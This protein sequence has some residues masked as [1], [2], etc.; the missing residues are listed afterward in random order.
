MV[1]DAV[2]DPAA[3][4]GSGEVPQTRRYDQGAGTAGG[5]AERYCGGDG[6]A[7]SQGQ[8][9]RQFSGEKDSVKERTPRASH[10]DR[11]R[12]KERENSIKEFKVLNKINQKQKPKKQ[13]PFYEGKT[14]NKNTDIEAVTDL[15][16]SAPNVSKI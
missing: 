6:N 7:T 1:C 12:A 15:Q 10:A 8:V 3:V 4:A 14:K 2:G 11:H 5:S 9:V 13:K 16:L